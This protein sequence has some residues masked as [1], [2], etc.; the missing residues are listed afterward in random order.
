MKFIVF[1]QLFGIESL[2]GIWRSMDN[3]SNWVQVAVIFVFLDKVFDI[4]N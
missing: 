4:L 3:D 1:S 2:A